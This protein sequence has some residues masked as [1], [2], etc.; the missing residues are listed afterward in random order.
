MALPDR[1]PASQHQ[2]ARA[3]SV[4]PLL[5][6]L[7]PAQEEGGE[8]WD[9]WESGAENGLVRAPARAQYGISGQLLPSAGRKAHLHMAVIEG[10]L[11]RPAPRPLC[12]QGLSSHWKGCE[13]GSGLGSGRGADTGEEALGERTKFPT[14]K[15]GL[16]HH[17]STIWG[18]AVC[19]HQPPI[20]P[21]G[22]PAWRLSPYRQLVRAGL[23]S[24]SDSGLDIQ[25]YCVVAISP[26]YPAILS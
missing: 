6:S 26:P 20:R 25:E 21:R 18:K 16:D 3:H 15:E 2:H 12:H 17:Y 22:W 13:R 9:G 1:C 11:E 8:R 24:K 4:T 7:F 10:L 23:E 5:S 14:D 19:L